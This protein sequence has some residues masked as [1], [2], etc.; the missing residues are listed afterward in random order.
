MGNIPQ[1]YTYSIYKTQ[2]LAIMISVYV[3]DFCVIVVL[4][5]CS[6]CWFR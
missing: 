4:F 5:W 6:I 1:N 3:I 2:T